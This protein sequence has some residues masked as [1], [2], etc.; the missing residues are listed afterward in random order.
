VNGGNVAV[1][2]GLLAALLAVVAIALLV[3]L[4]GYL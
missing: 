4:G 1:V 2:V 3:M